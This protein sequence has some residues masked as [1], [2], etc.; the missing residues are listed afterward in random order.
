LPEINLVGWVVTCHPLLQPRPAVL[1]RI[2]LGMARWKAAHSDVIVLAPSPDDVGAMA[3]SVVEQE[4]PISEV[5]PL[6]ADAPSAS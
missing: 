4:R 1:D 2:E 6:A 5:L 3:G